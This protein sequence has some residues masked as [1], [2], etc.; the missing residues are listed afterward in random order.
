MSG[1]WLFTCSPLGRGGGGADGGG[2]ASDEPPA[3][4][5]PPDPAAVG[6]RQAVGR[7][8]RRARVLR[9]VRGA[10]TSYHTRIAQKSIAVYTTVS[11]NNKHSH[12][13]G[14]GRVHVVSG[15]LQRDDLLL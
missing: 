13:V 3:G 8:D 5:A 4:P 15:L 11:L 9:Q 10:V 1:C 12:S 6:R 7:R 2:E 14:Q